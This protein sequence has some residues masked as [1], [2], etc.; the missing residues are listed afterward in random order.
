M[1]ENI[2]EAYL[3]YILEN[4]HS[5]K[6]M[7]SPER[8]PTTTPVIAKNNRQGQRK[9]K[10]DRSAGKESKENHL[11]YERLLKRQRFLFFFMLT[12]CVL[13]LIKLSRR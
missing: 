9:S 7:Q 11:S 10:T 13:L 5:C 12:L 1:D 6:Q 3:D 2:N 8:Q 4:A